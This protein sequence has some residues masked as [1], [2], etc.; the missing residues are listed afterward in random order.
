VTKDPIGLRGG[1]NQYSYVINNPVKDRD[2]LGLA[3]LD[4]P[5]P[6][7]NPF[8]Q[9]LKTYSTS[10]CGEGYKKEI[11]KNCI[12]DRVISNAGNYGY[13]FTAMLIPWPGN[14]VGGV[15]AIGVTLRIA[16]ECD[17]IAQTCSYSR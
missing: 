13:A 7:E 1:I 10:C 15:W 14:I 3:P 12:L 8:V 4:T 2:P 9:P 11:Y 6:W 16:D 5:D 17:K